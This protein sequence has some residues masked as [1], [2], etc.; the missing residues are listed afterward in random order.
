MPR[1]PW[2]S[3]PRCDTGWLHGREGVESAAVSLDWVVANEATSSPMSIGEVYHRTDLPSIG[4]APEPPGVELSLLR[5]LGASPPAA[6]RAAAGD[7]VLRL[8]SSGPPGPAGYRCARLRGEP[9]AM[10]NSDEAPLFP[11]PVLRPFLRTQTPP[12]SHR[13]SEASTNR[14]RASFG[15]DL[16]P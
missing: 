15:V 1:G 4:S 10:S 12:A 7:R 11:E 2:M 5:D 6:L 14:A 9:G 3:I 8:Y 13:P 16:E